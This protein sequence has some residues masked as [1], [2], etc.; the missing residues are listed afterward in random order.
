MR[1]KAFTLIEILVVVTIIGVLSAAG[2]TSYVRALKNGRDGRR[3]SDISNI[4]QALVMYRYEN[5]SYPTSPSLSTNWRNVGSNFLSTTPVDPLNTGNYTY[6]YY[7]SDNGK[8]FRLCALMENTSNGNT[9]STTGYTLS[10]AAS[11]TYYC[12]VNP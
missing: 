1:R 4:Q 8:R 2:V 10:P 7:L 11:G 5:G 12:V 3:K 6:K 9:N